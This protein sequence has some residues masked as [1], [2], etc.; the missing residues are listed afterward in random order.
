M[1]EKDS[2]IMKKLFSL[3]L[4][5]AII[6]LSFVSCSSESFADLDKLKSGDKYI[7][8]G[9]D[10]NMDFAAAADALKISKDSNELDSEHT[11]NFDGTDYKLNKYVREDFSF[12]GKKSR[13]TL[14]FTDEKLYGVQFSY[15]DGDITKMY[16]DLKAKMKEK[17]GEYEEKESLPELKEKFGMSGTSLYWEQSDT[18]LVLSIH[19]QDDAATG[20]S[21]GTVD[22]TKVLDKSTLNK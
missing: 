10:Y 19:Y 20:V 2:E 12:L 6:A 16:E 4:V 1:N 9:L 7:Y 17:F 5:L 11:T 18:R 15:S 22:L 8:S 21:V 3:S 14:D 13:I